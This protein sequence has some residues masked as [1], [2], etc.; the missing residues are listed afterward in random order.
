MDAITKRQLLEQGFYC[1][2]TQ[3]FAHALEVGLDALV[4]NP[5]LH[6]LLSLSLNY[7][8]YL[9]KQENLNRKADWAKI[10]HLEEIRQVLETNLNELRDH[11]HLLKA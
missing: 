4:G 11:I 5:P 3:I 8:K 10:E 6:S 9:A 2:S 7:G 1:S